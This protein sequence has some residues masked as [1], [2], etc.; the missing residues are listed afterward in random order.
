[1]HSV[2][3]LRSHYKIHSE[4]FQAS[5]H[6]GSPNDFSLLGYESQQ[7]PIAHTSRPQIF[8]AALFELNGRHDKRLDVIPCAEGGAGCSVCPYSFPAVKQ[9]YTHIST[10]IY[11]QRVCA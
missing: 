9:R 3:T 1:M 11:I 4:K 5:S 7:K 10:C 8:T 2:Y 6:E